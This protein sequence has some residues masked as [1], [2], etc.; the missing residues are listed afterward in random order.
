MLR[1]RRRRRQRIYVVIERVISMTEQF[2]PLDR[3]IQ[4]SELGDKQEHAPLQARTRKVCSPQRPQHEALEPAVGGLTG[5][6]VM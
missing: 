4:A 5:G 6:A 3:A 2:G 1:S